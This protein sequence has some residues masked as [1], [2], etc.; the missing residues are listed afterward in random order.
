LHG[1]ATWKRRSADSPSEIMAA[2]SDMPG[3]RFRP[4]NIF[5]KCIDHI[6]A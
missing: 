1:R 5:L 6:H 3:P 4:E 2:A